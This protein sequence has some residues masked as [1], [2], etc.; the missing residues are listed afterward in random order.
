MARANALLIVPEDRPTVTA[1][2]ILSGLLLDDPYH[3]AEAPF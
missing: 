1:G 3:V 2:E